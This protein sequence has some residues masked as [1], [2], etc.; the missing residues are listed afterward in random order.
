LL[1][2][3]ILAGIA[4]TAQAE[5]APG[6]AMAAEGNGHLETVDRVLVTYPR[7]FFDRYQPVT[8]LDMVGQVP[9]FRLDD[10]T[11]DVR[12][13]AE[14]AGNVLI[15]DRRPSSKR[16]S[17][18][19][20]LARIP[21]SAVQRIELIRGQVR[22]IDLRGQAEV[23]NLV[24]REGV[25]AQVQWQA[26]AR[27][28]FGFGPVSPIGSIA[29]TDRWGDV[30]VNVGLRGRR[31]SVGRSGTEDVF[32]AAGNPLE[33]RSEHR[34]NGNRFLT[35]S[36]NASSGRG[37]TIWQ[38]NATL[39]H[40][41]RKTDTLSDRLDTVTGTGETI[42]FA[43]EEEEPAYEIGFDLERALAA[44]LVG[45]AIFLGIRAETDFEDT[46]TDYDAAGNRTLFREAKGALD[47]TEV[48]TRVEFDLN[49][50]PRHLVQANVERAFN[51][52]DSRL[53]Q[54]DDTGTGPIIIDVPGA[55]SRVE[56]ERWDIVLQDTWTLGKLELGYGIGAEASTIRQTG[57]A[58]LER[59]FFFLKPQ[60]VLNYSS[61]GSDQTRLRIAREIAQLD[62]EDFVSATEFL[63]DDLALG[64]PN[65]K[66]D[67][68]WKLELSRE[69]RLGTEGVVKITAFHD[70]ISDV[71][72]LLPL[73]PDFEAPGNIGDGRRWGLRL[74]ST[75][76]L[77]ALGITDG[78]L[79]LKLRWQD[80]S[81]TDPV[82]GDD[83]VLSV[84]QI[85][86][87]PVVFDIENEYAYEVEFRQDFRERRA[88]WGVGLAER[89]EQLQF[90]VNELEIYDEGSDVMAFVETTRWRD[91][92]IRLDWE[93][94]LDFAD[95]RTRRIFSAERDLSPLE[96]VQFRDRTRGR[97]LQLSFSGS[98]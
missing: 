92:K 77:D 93:N 9:G 65:I 74:E 17:L 60:L 23:V 19:D 22:N 3:A 16:D 67:S 98:F 39:N 78:R 83:R 2:V 79:D 43:D 61:A 80:S 30:D 24:M 73:T 45:K 37:E 59:D 81:V 32:D 28:T 5:E 91:I 71:L 27:K 10:D 4:G 33:Y 12:G 72:D 42:F 25:P 44:D 64:N 31:N 84:G 29:L 50:Y 54:T 94:I 86:G 13:F 63:D 90:K 53:V 69:Q 15:N 96:S 57:D 36:L 38:L 88:A 75:L 62:L 85:S 66:P 52:L 1:A 7:R 11:N 18:S 6:N 89:A 51:A 55:N 21:A 46:Q 68:T 70:W 8:A 87:G 14:A 95:E 58:E 49:R 82:T 97:R 35:A 20:I 26:A 41:R 48:I 56:E 34:D 47:S 76:P 40:T